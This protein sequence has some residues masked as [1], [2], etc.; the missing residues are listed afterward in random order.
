[1]RRQSTNGTVA[2]SEPAGAGFRLSRE[3][4]GL[5]WSRVLPFRLTDDGV[6]VH[7]GSFDTASRFVNAHYAELF[8]ERAD[9]PFATD[10]GGAAK[11]RYYALAGDFFELRHDGRM[12]GL[13]VCRP[14]WR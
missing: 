2:A 14:T 11:A 9:G 12:V 7:A 8:E 10:V 3:V 13:L 5:D 1:M 6:G 4:W